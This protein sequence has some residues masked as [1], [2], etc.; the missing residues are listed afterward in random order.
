[1][2]D[3]PLNHIDRR[4]LHL[5]QVDARGK[6]DTDIAEET[7]VTGTTVANRIERLEDRGIIRGYHPEID[8]EE[9]GYPLVILFVGTVPVT[10]R[11]TIADQARDVLGVVDVKQLL[12]GEENIHVQAVAESTDRIEQ[13]TEELDSI[14]LQIHRSD[15][16]SEHTTQPWDHFHIEVAEDEE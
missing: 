6:R 5:L 2:D 8:Y 7:D 3:E 11:K 15:I 16:I 1:M 14:G 13:I 9:A 10:E 12:S 4:I